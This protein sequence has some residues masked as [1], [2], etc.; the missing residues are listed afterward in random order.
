LNVISPSAALPSPRC[1]LGDE[2]LHREG[3]R[4][5]GH[6]AEP[7]DARVRGG[8]RVLDADIGDRERHV[9]HAHAELERVLVLPPSTKVEKMVGATLRCSQ[10][11]GLP[12]IALDRRVRGGS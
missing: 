8:L 11:T 1:Q 9:D 5:V 4:N 2:R 10:A 12:S 6:R 3:M 7:A